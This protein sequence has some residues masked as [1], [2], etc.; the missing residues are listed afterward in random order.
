MIV[1]GDQG[2]SYNIG[3]YSSING[4]VVSYTNGDYCSVV[5]RNRR[6]AF[7]IVLTS[8]PNEN[9]ELSTSE[10]SICVYVFEKKCYCEVVSDIVFSKSSVTE[11]AL[12]S[13]FII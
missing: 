13:N 4:Q 9:G 3:T 7:E 6:G 11:S 8:D 1:Q 10:P 12:S 2:E 5:G